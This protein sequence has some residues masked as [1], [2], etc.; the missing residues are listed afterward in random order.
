MIV[1]II[2]GREGS[3]A[4]PGK[5]VHPVLGRPLTAYPLMAAQ[6]SRYIDKTYMSTD[7]PRLQAIAREYGA[8]VLERPEEL[9]TSKAL[10]EDAY[11]H[12]YRWIKDDLGEE[13]EIV[14]L[15]FCNAATILG[16]TIDEGIERLREDTELDSAVTV[17][18]YNM[19]SPIRARRIDEQGLIQPFA[20]LESYGD[21]NE[22]TCDRD[23][24][25]DVY[26]ADGGVS[27]VR[28]R[29][30]EDLE[31]GVLP[32][33]WMGQRIHP[34]IQTAG[35]DVDYAWQIPGVRAWLLEHG[36]TDTKTAYED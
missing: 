15:L 20:P 1:A 33:R 7:S 29:C 28:P 16:S 2:I 14:V 21:L 30:L 35:C 24:Q 13:I 10:A 4:F 26:F 17:S 6:H 36:F 8:E 11:A 32:H 5:N 25:G 12:A 19:W 27:I 31:Y 18:R 22:F 3:V 9:A 23:S 34:L